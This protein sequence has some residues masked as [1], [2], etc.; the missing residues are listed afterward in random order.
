MNS[1]VYKMLA[2]KLGAMPD[3]FEEP[4]EKSASVTI[5]LGSPESEE[6]EEKCETCGKLPC[7]C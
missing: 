3:S 6:K 1:K 7:E 2:E 4:K 5:M